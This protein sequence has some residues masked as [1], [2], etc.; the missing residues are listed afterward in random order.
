MKNCFQK[1]Y[2]LVVTPLTVPIRNVNGDFSCLISSQQF[3]FY[4]WTQM[5]AL[6]D[7]S[8]LDAIWIIRSSIFPHLS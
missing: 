2:L 7:K 4:K 1:N 3:C 6:P 8:K 5:T